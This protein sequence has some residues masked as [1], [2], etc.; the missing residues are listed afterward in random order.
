MDSNVPSFASLLL[1]WHHRVNQRAMPWKGEKDPYKI[2]LSEVILQQTRVEQGWDYYERFI[3]SFPTVQALAAAED[4][5][6]FRLWEGLGYYARCRNLLHTARRV[7]FEL[8]GV[9]PSSY[10]DLLAL[11][12]VGP[13]TAAAIASF[14][15]DLPHA[16]VDGNVQRI[17]A[18]YFGI[19]TPVQ[20]PAGKRLYQELAQA[21]LDPA[22]PAHFNQAMLDLGATI[23]KPQAPRCD[24][25]PQQAD[26]QSFKYNWTAELPLKVVKAAKKIRHLHYF[27][28][29][30]NHQ[31]LVRERTGKDIWQH[32]FEFVL[33]E[34]D[35]THAI[36]NPDFFPNRHMLP[37]ISTQHTEPIKQQLTHQQLLIYIHPVP[38]TEDPGTPE[39]Y[40]WVDAKTLFALPFPKTLAA[41]RKKITANI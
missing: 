37:E 4:A 33:V 19:T 11:K 23:C 1:D 6:V 8:G 39:T 20:A 31:W 7:A 30:W 21:L 10:T 40:Q 35:Q 26:C 36:L 38:C 27:V 22:S 16:V 41:Y 24:I 25:C 14:A 32:L 34:S 28:V 17:L 29:E 3:R 2:W 12:G 18:R 9:F 13:Y 5:V 15:F